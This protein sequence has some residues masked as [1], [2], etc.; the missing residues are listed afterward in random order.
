MIRTN[1]ALRSTVAIAAMICGAAQL[2]TVLMTD[3]PGGVADII[4]FR[5][6]GKIDMG[7]AAATATMPNL[8]GFDDHSESKYVRMMALNITAITGLTD[9]E[10]QRRA[11]R[12]SKWAA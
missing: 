8:L 10:G 1:S 9:F 7:L 4:S 11:R 5:T 3:F 2:A 6:H 12:R